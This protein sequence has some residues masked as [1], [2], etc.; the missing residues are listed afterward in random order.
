MVVA[1]EAYQEQLGELNEA[2]RELGELAVKCVRASGD[3]IVKK[4]EDAISGIFSDHSKSARLRRSIEDSCMNLMLLQQPMAS[5]LRFVTAA[6]R[7]VSDLGRILDMT[8]D[9]ADISSYLPEG[10]LGG[11]EDKMSVLAVESAD[12]VEQAVMAFYDRDAKQAEAVFSLDD[13]VDA[14]FMA[15]R[16]AVVDNVRKN[17]DAVVL[18]PDI[19][20]VAKYFER[21]GDHAQAFADWAIFRVTGAYRGQ[22]LGTGE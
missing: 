13:D 4:D 16:D 3:A 12:M 14:A 15:V 11:L 7:S 9:I 18:A 8:F 22:L 6:F 21:I 5:D 2:V 10:A 20:T 1:R 19:L 17:E